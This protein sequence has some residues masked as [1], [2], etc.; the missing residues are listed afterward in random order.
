MGVMFALTKEIIGDESPTVSMIGC[1]SRIGV[2][3]A[4]KEDEEE[5]QMFKT[6]GC[7]VL[8]KLNEGERK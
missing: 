3:P 8:V 6:P 4:N 1:D 5:F 2:V 7:P